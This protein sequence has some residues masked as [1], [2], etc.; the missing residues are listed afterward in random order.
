MA[1]IVLA[2][3]GLAAGDG[4]PRMG[5]AR[6]PVA[7]PVNLGAEFRG[8]MRLAGGPLRPAELA[9]G[10]LL[11]KAPGGVGFFGGAKLAPDGPGRFR[12]TFLGDL[13]G[14]A[15]REGGKIVL[16]LDLPAAT[17]VSPDEWAALIGM[18][19]PDTGKP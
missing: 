15:R 3:A 14:T 10:R 19:K 1:G 11:V 13:R 18:L 2:L 12:L 16:T 7:E 5:A 8:Y 6:E 9:K 17:P 4:G